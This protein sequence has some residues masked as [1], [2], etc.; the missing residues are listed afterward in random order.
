MGDDT[1]LE[2]SKQKFFA[3]PCTYINKLLL[4]S[5]NS[6]AIAMHRSPPPPLISPPAIA[7]VSCTAFKW[8]P[9]GLGKTANYAVVMANLITGGKRRGPQPFIVKLRDEETHE[10]LPGIKGE[11]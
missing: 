6:P 11:L 10:P 1:L 3:V 8:W 2:K 5:S 4:S 9:G 7:S